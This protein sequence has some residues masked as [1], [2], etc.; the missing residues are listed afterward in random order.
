M[1]KSDAVCEHCGKMF[2]RPYSRI[3][4]SKHNFCSKECFYNFRR[5]NPNE[6]GDTGNRDSYRKL[7]EFARIRKENIL[8]KQ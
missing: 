1:V 8:K 7:K 4:K 6:W 3:K 5:E 2:S